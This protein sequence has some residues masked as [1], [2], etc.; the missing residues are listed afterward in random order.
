MKAQR[1]VTLIEA[2]VALLVMSFGMVALVGLM[3]NLRRTTDVAKQRSDAMRIAQADLANLRAFSLLTKPAGSAPGVQDYDT[4]ISNLSASPFTLRDTNA[5]FTLERTVT[6]LVKDQSEPKAQTVQVTV[7]WTDRTGQAEQLVLNSVIA[8][9]DPAFSG[10]LGIAPP[11]YGLRSP[12]NRN[13]AVPMN[14]KDLDGKVSAFRPDANGS[15]VWV[16]NNLTGVVVG[17][18]SILVNTVITAADVDSCSNNT[19]GYLISGTVRFSTGATAN[20]S[21]P[22]TMAMPLG[23]YMALTPSEF[24]VRDRS[25]ALVLAPGGA[26]SVSPPYECFSDAPLS[27]SATQSF[28]NYNCIVYP[29]SQTPRNW[30]GRVLLNG[31]DIGTSAA[32]F[33]VCRYSA[34]YNGNGYT[35]QQIVNGTVT[36]FKIDNEEHPDIYRGVS[37]SLTRQNFLVVRGDVA[38][39]AAPAVDPAAGVFLDYST[40]QLQPTP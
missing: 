23:V 35:Y 29:N 19:V 36:T 18:C 26:Y 8:R 21:A 2:L 1:G 31:L 28:V 22:D 13:P 17:K 7:R 5:T 3:S 10:A 32:Q 24:K 16:F 38:C 27:A 14:A 11:V 12:G 20:P 39:P 33:K 25:G 9:I 6:P 15:T 34:D 30:W 4:D 40:L 37:Y